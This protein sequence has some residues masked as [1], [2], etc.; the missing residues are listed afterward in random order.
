MKINIGA[1][2]L[3][4]STPAVMT[5]INVTPDS[6]YGGSR[7]PDRTAVAAR[8][9][10]AVGEGATILDIGGYSS[11]PGAEDVSVEQ[12]TARVL[13]GVEVVRER[14]PDMVI[15]IDTFRSAV[16]R[17][18]VARWGAC[19]VNDISAGELDPQMI[20]TVAELELPY[21]A[22]H[23]RGRPQ[24]MQQQTDYHDVVTEVRGYF[25]QKMCEL[26]RAGVRDV[27]LDPG[28]GFAKSVEQN[29]QLLRSLGDLG[30]SGRPLLVGLS[31]KS[32]IYKVLGTT[33]EESL[34]GTVALNWEAL[35]GG[36]SILRVHDTREAVET[37]KLYEKMVNS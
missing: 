18:V 14:Y 10:C 25:E 16:V 32:M 5:I 28:F 9:E 31:R 29:Y 36:A 35:R 34:V 17:A 37:V 2:V 3:D 21:I 24:T 1:Q 27:I 15:S 8:I 13:I 20:P 11:R 19:I 22:M 30:I 33:P 6:F 23:M 12:E 7:T 26:E 4:L